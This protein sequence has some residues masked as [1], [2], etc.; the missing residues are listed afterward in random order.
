MKLIF[1]FDDGRIDSY[2]AS[3]ILKK[4]E[5][6]GSFFVVTGFVDGSFKTTVF[7]DS[8]KP[9][10]REML[11]KMKNDGHEIA[12]HG[13]KHLTDC[14]DFETSYHKL[15]EWKLCDQKVGFSVPNSKASFSE[16]VS[17]YSIEKNRISYIRTGRNERCYTFLNKVRYVL[18]RLL[19]FQFLFNHFNKPN[20]IFNSTETYFFNSI[21]VKRGTKSKSVIK[22]LK[23]YSSLDCTLILMFHS[24]VDKPVDVW[25]YSKD[26]FE[27]ICEY[28]SQDK[29]ID[30]IPLKDLCND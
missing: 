25:E 15:R 24:V 26:D 17:F 12:S 5:I 29:K 18:F 11:L 9:L 13:D 8:R 27:A 6:C 22:F 23:K 2:E 30:A 3:Q 10:T 14:D 4:H 21:V 1:T 19:K 20:L 28:A 7:G 16:L